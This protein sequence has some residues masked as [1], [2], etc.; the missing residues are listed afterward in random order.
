MDY[1]ELNANKFCF[2]TFDLDLT[3][4]VK[5]FLKYIPAGGRVLD[6]GCGSGRDACT[7]KKLGYNVA[8]FDSSPAM[9]EIAS[10]N[11]GQKVQC[12]SF[13]DIDYDCFFDGI[14]ACASLLHV[15]RD[16]L[17]SVLSKLKK[18]VILNGCIYVSFKL[19]DAER[20][21]KH[22]R[23]FNDLNEEGLNIILKKTDGLI[24]KEMWI[25]Q[26]ARPDRNDEFWLNAIL[27]AK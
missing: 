8:A 14:W 20:V 5:E 18:S 15:K 22:G 2:A 10:R 1:Y 6:A 4:I 7:F 17:A 27:I 23:Y 16:D 3:S 13:Y 11:L 26:D 9:V 24:S 21:D 25:T 19:G 12:M